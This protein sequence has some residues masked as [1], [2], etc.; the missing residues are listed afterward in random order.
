MFCE[1]YAP[2][3]AFG[4][5]KEWWFCTYVSPFPTGFV[6]VP[7]IS[8]PRCKDPSDPGALETHASHWTDGSCEEGC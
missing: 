6:E 4:T 3:L 1:S 7:A 2:K 8:V 5:S